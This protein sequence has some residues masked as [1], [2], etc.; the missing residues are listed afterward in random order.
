[1]EVDFMGF[2]ILLAI[3]GLIV[4]LGLGY[5]FEKSRHEKEIAG[6][7]SSAA[8]ILDSAR[9]EAETLKKEALLEAKEENQKYRS[10]V[11]SELRESRVRI[12]ISRKSFD[13]A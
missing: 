3:I 4:G 12:K 10:E 11:E 5:V 2:S 9:K 13:P 1:M 6:A 7:Q 8:G